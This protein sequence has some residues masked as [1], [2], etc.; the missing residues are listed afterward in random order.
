MDPLVTGYFF[1]TPQKGNRLNPGIHELKVSFRP[2]N[3]ESMEVV[4]IKNTIEVWKLCPIIKWNNPPS[5]EYGE[6]LSSIQLNAIIDSQEKISGMFKYDPSFDSIL[7]VG[8][9]IIQV[10]FFPHD[11][12]LFMEA[13]K[14]VTIRIKPLISDLHWENPS[15][16]PYGIALTEDQLNAI[17]IGTYLNIPG[18]YIYE[19]SLGEVL[20][21]GMQELNVTFFPFDQT[22]HAPLNKSVS[23]I[24]EK[25]DTIALL[26]WDNPV[27]I[28]FGEELSSNQL[29]AYCKNSDIRGL[30]T[31]DPDFLTILDVGIHPLKVLFT[32]FENDKYNNSTKTVSLVVTPKE[33]TISWRKPSEIIYGT[34]LT[35]LQLC[36][37]CDVKSLT[38]KFFYSPS[39]GELLTAGTHKLTVLFSP[40][41]DINYGPAELSVVLSIQKKTP[42]IIWDA[43][44][45][46]IIFI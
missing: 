37:H 3:T 9:N 41:N 7:P 12:D 40:E 11:S 39:F 17:C 30:Y 10:H 45:R 34:I 32:P 2:E 25:L 33:S 24:V 1:Y 6:S 13:Q 44:Y 19:P 38:G 26:Q 35:E 42:I 20:K 27:S 46:F 16:I 8:D 36:A 22:F 14:S 43:L 21:T 28:C 15:P 18:E 5:I 4:E 29:N 31:Y 23:L